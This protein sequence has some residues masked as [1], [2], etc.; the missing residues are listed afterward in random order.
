MV[1]LAVSVF[2]IGAAGRIINGGKTTVVYG[3]AFAVGERSARS[4][5]GAVTLDDLAANKLMAEGAPAPRGDCPL[6]AI[7]T[8]EPGLLAFYQAALACLDATWRPV[9]AARGVPFTV[10]RVT[11]TEWSSTRCGFTPAEDEALAFYCPGD[12][13]IAMPHSRMIRTADDNAG[14]HLAVLAH[15]YGH[16]L[17]LL[18]GILEDAALLEFDLDEAGAAE[19]S[20][21][22]ELQANCLAGVFLAAARLA[23]NLV[24]DADSSFADTTSS[25]SHGS[26]ENQVHWAAAGKRSATPA[27][28]DTWSAPDHEVS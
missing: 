5:P 15:E 3:Q 19:V 28:C 16:H 22:A 10:P 14:Y 21:R 25:D 13:M 24:D 23:P 27:G 20:R 1:I 17:Q 2:S 11:V 12:R 8:T 7:D 18:S 9:L 6:P 26:A 4:R